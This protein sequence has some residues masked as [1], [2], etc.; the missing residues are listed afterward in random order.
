M[1]DHPILCPGCGQRATAPHFRDSP[2][3]AK[4][5]ASLAAIYNVSRRKTVGKSTGRPKVLKAC[6]RCGQ[7]VSTTEARYG[8]D[9]CSVVKSITGNGGM[10]TV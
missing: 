4:A 8:H 6:P 2:E 5:A 10:N 7:T 3:C 1:T 9:G